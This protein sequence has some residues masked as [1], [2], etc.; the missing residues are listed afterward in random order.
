MT[1]MG[2]QIMTKKLSLKMGNDSAH[3][4]PAA[5]YFSNLVVLNLRYFVMFEEPIPLLLFLKSH[6][7][8]QE[9]TCEWSVTAARLHSLSA[10]ELRQ[11]ASR[12]PHQAET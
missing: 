9:K 5:V 7:T 1:W 3:F 6:V 11:K 10:K 4:Y 12:A 8:S 2:W